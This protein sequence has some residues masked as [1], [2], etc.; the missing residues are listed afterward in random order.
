MR[1]LLSPGQ[2][3]AK[4]IKLFSEERNFERSDIAKTL[5]S[6]LTGKR[7][8]RYRIQKLLFNFSFLKKYYV[9][10]LFTDILGVVTENLYQRA[11]GL[12]IRRINTL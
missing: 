8:G 12:V 10:I 4:R 11:H 9:I 1:C 2:V 7:R 3:P 6:L 5:S